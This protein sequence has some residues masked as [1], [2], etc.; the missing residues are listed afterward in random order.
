MKSKKKGL[1]F[2]LENLF[3]FKKKIWPKYI[4]L[5]DENHS[6]SSDRDKRWK[7]LF[8][9]IIF[10]SRKNKEENG[11]KSKRPRLQN[12]I[13]KKQ[14]TPAD[15]LPHSSKQ[16]PKSQLETDAKN[17]DQKNKNQ[18]NQI[19]STELSDISNGK[20]NDQ[21]DH[22]IFLNDENFDELRN[23]DF[24]ARSSDSDSKVNNCK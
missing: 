6:T 22:K 18:T 3:R 4:V 2:F 20:P 24:D 21:S 14:S 9:V 23:S 12:P 15:N 1:H 19:N 16:E 8:S 13:S 10:W 7:L 17:D 5:I 11:E